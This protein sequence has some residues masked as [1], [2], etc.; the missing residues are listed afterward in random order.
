MKYQI[1]DSTVFTYCLIPGHLERDKIKRL[2]VRE[3]EQKKPT[4]MTLNNNNNNNNKS[5]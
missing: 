4:W 1:A 3:V 5:E 2:L